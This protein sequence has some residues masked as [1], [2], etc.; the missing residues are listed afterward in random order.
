MKKVEFGT[1]TITIPSFCTYLILVVPCYSLKYRVN[2]IN[3]DLVQYHYIASSFVRV[4]YTKNLFIDLLQLAY[5]QFKCHTIAFKEPQFYSH[6]SFTSAYEFLLN[7]IV[8]FDINWCGFG[9]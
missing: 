5:C 8:Y 7:I 3:M 6:S 4:S 9:Y 2:T 1:C